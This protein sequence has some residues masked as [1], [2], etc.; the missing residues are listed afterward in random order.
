VLWRLYNRAQR[1]A[2]LY[3]QLSVK[4]APGIKAPRAMN[5]RVRTL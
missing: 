2:D 3:F 5:L 4:E 1:V